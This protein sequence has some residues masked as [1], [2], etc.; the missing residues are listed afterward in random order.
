MT[1]IGNKPDLGKFEY[2]YPKPSNTLNI[3]TEHGLVSKEK[4][5]A[6]RYLEQM[7]TKT[8]LTTKKSTHLD[9]NG[10]PNLLFFTTF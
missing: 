10:K 2:V 9:I 6:V 7:L 1:A 8:S 5:P 4:T 3:F